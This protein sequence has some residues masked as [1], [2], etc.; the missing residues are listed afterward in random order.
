LEADE[1]E[2]ELARRYDAAVSGTDETLVEHK[3]VEPER[4]FAA[5]EERA[6]NRV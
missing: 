6:R 4:T 2:S 5:L 3:R 1:L